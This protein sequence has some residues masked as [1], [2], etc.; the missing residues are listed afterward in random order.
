MSEQGKGRFTG[1]HMVWTM[2]GGFGVVAA[3]NFYMASLA[4][5]GFHGIV[6]E[7]SYV[8][9]QKFNDWIDEADQMEALGWG[10]SATHLDD[11]HV[12][13]ATKGV[14]EGAVVRAALRRPIGTK[15][16]A[17]LTFA[18]A[19]EGKFWSLE[20]VA[21]GRWTIRVTI[22]ADG[23]TWAQEHALP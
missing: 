15:Q 19:G 11:G 21:D 18:P 13:I 14:P 23:D 16:F 20:P 17:D 4:V 3:V 5:G 10:A 1:K 7:N 9:S 8:A 2:V 6:V 22:E 12:L